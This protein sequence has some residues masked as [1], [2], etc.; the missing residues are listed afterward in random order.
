MLED[1]WMHTYFDDPK[2]VTETV[3]DDDFDPAQVA[4][5]LKQREPQA[6]AAGAPATPAMPDDFEPLT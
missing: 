1:F 4:E 6:A 2:A 3:E 5:L